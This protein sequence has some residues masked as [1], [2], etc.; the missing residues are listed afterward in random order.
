MGWCYALKLEARNAFP[1]FLYSLLQNAIV[2]EDSKEFINI[3][4]GE[5]EY[6]LFFV[7]ESKNAWISRQQ[8]SQYN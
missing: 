1:H 5:K 4:E 7:F 6:W 2:G 3:K 8:S